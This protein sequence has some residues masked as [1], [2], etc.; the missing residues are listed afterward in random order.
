MANTCENL[1][2]D[3]RTDFLTSRIIQNKDQSK[4]WKDFDSYRNE[5]NTALSI[6]SRF[7]VMLWMQGLES[8]FLENT[9]EQTTLRDVAKTRL[10][11]AIEDQAAEEKTSEKDEPVEVVE[12]LKLPAKPKSKPKSKAKAKSTTKKKSK[13]RPKGSKNKPSAP[14]K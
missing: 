14:E 4:V 7:E 6:K 11:A 1:A 12:E 13:G 5:D 2:E 8:N 9:P 10:D 3:A